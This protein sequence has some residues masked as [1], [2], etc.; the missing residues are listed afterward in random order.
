[1]IDRVINVLKS[2]RESV[3]KGEINCIP[4]NFKRFSNNIPG[5]EKDKYYIISGN[6]KSGKSQLA[7]FM[8]LYTLLFKYH[9]K[10]RS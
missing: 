5:I 3:L 8:F 9:I 6:T 4:F 1:M 2:R 7:N 10:P